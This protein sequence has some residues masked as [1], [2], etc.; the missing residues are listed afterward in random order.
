[1]LGLINIALRYKE[2]FHQSS[3]WLTKTALIKPASI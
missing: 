3:F 2:Y 1:V